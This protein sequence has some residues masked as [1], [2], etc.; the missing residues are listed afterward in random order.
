[1]AR[2][3]CAEARPAAPP[4]EPLSFSSELEDP[5]ANAESAVLGA[6]RADVDLLAL[7]VK[8]NPFIAQALGGLR[9]DSVRAMVTM[10]V[11]R[12]FLVRYYYWLLPYA[13][14]AKSKY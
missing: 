3:V 6:L 5:F 7:V 9:R 10:S 11:G 2:R 1:L 13:G 4:C 12:G 14:Y 8:R